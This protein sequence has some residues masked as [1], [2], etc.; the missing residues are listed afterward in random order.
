MFKDDTLD[1]LGIIGVI[2]AAIITGIGITVANNAGKIRVA[3]IQGSY[4][5]EYWLAKEAE[6]NERVRKHEIDVAA[7]ERLKLDERERQDAARRE[8]LEFEKGA[9]A[10]YWE[11]RRERERI[12]AKK[13][14]AEEKA[15]TEKEIATQRAKALENSATRIA[16]AFNE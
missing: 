11:Y 6:A 9:P 3:E 5:P 10:E 12:E 15:K 2:G 1:L 4:G 7:K 14:I 16:A 13:K 8:R